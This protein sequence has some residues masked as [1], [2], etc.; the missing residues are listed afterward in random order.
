VSRYQRDYELNP[1]ERLFKV[2]GELWV[3][4]KELAAF[5][6][7]RPE[8]IFL[9]PNVT[10][11][12]NDFILGAPLPA[13]SEIL[14]SNLEYGAILNLCRFRTEREGLSLRTFPLPLASAEL[15]NLTEDAL[16]ERVLSSLSASTGMLVLSDVITANGLLL[17]IAR[18]A[19]ETRKR[20]VLL[21]VDGAHAPGSIPLDFAALED[22]DFYG[23]NLHKWMMGAKGSAFGWVAPRNQ[24]KLC[25]RYAG[26]TNFEAH[27]AFAAFGGGS[28]FQHRSLWSSCHDFAPWLAI[29]ETLAFWQ[30]LGPENIRKRI[31]DLQS[32]TEREMESLDLPLLSPPPKLRGPLL[33]YDLP[34]S[35][36]AEGFA[37][38][39]RVL[40][41][42]QLQ[43]HVSP[44]QGRNRLRFSPHIYNNEAEIRNAVTILK[45]VLR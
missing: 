45:E 22:V 35:V 15:K 10:H 44:Q 16:L 24:E 12:L 3:R 5:L 38:M 7:A 4:Q 25:E 34:D 30:R 19:A 14:L 8:D 40:R 41:Q 13:K 2:W 31:Y 20:G 37:L 42:Y 26:W 1:T 17:P 23:G 43:I 18:I 11:A 21:V 36:Q 28:R 6:R 32:F 9:R 29:R 33:T 39:A 27:P